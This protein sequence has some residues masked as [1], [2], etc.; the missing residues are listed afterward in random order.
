[1]TSTALPR[2]AAVTLGVERLLRG[3]RGL[4]EGR[5]LGIVCNPASIDS[6][7]RHTAD[8]L[9]ADSAVT[10]TALFGPQHGFRSDLQDNMIETPHATDR[11]RL[12]PIYSLYSE[13]REPTA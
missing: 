11:R 4:V 5:R 12:V 6:A 9:S 2:T 10:V 8:V 3:E 1:M 13:T 7:F